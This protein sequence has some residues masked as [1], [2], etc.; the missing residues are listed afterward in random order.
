MKNKNI[1]IIT[2]ELA[3]GKTSYGRKI[4]QELK[5][6]FFSKDEIK[7]I[8]FDSVN[9]INSDYYAKQKVGAHSYAI[10][11]YI[12]EMQMK[13][14]MSLIVESNFTKESADIIKKLINK[15]NYNSITLRFE[16][17]LQILHKRFL[18]REN[19]SERHKGLVSNGMFDDFENFKKTA[20]KSK[21]FK[22]N[23][24]EILIDTTNF[25]DIN[26]NDIIKNI[27][28]NIKNY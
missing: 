25:S 23:D 1:I 21:E 13:V 8:L 18:K 9:N 22:I 16:G 5:L 6:P 24:N 11:Y 4:S 20:I 12:M 7:E 3:S 14:G 10:L 2:G 19:S 27:Q 17:D 28:D 15:Y 26:F